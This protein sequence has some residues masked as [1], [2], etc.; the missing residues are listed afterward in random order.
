MKIIS[1]ICESVSLIIS[2]LGVIILISILKDI[3]D[4]IRYIH[5]RIDNIENYITETIDIDSTSTIIEED[6]ETDDYY[7]GAQ[8]EY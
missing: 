5:H 1:I 3:K 2:G 4:E 6:K 8:E 7:R